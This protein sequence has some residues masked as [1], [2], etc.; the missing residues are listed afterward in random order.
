MPTSQ[1]YK[2]YHALRDNGV[3]V[4]FVAWPVGGHYPADPA[5]AQDVAR[6]WIDWLDEHLGE[7]GK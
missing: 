5:R 3:P 6:R 1:S 4:T 7:G 2:L